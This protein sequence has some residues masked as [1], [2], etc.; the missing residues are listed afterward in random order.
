MLSNGG[1]CCSMVKVGQGFTAY[2]GM[3]GVGETMGPCD[4]TVRMN[5]HPGGFAVDERI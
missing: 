1:R 4:W 5:E 3:R 2:Y